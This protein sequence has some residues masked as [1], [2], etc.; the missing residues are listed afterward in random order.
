MRAC[1]LWLLFFLFVCV[2]EKKHKML[3]NIYK[4]YG[5][6]FIAWDLKRWV[7]IEMVC[8]SGEYFPTIQSWEEIAER[9]FKS[10]AH[11]QYKL[12][13][14]IDLFLI[15]HGICSFSMNIIFE[16]LFFCCIFRKYFMTF[17]ESLWQ[18]HDTSGLSDTTC[19]P[20]LV[21]L[22]KWADFL[23]TLQVQWTIYINNLTL[24]PVSYLLSH[25]FAHFHKRSW[26]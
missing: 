16:T 25:H 23:N 5:C 3:A 10:H 6:S 12:A 20:I 18:P 17:K 11:L 22:R 19:S 4:D 26:A 24:C 1:N 7:S 14:S 21:I 13:I 2:F 8:P 9:E 15:K